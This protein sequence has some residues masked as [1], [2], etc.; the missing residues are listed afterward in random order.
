MKRKS[1]LKFILE[2]EINI[3]EMYVGKLH[4]KKRQK[5][6]SFAITGMFLQEFH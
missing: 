3:V 4:T 5:N 2:L 1:T 6:K